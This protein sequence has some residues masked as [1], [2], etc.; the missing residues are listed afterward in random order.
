MQ[1]FSWVRAGVSEDSRTAGPQGTAAVYGYGKGG[2][3][4][5]GELA[6]QVSQSVRQ[7]DRPESE[8]GPGQGGHCG[9]VACGYYYG[10]EREGCV[11][12]RSRGPMILWL[13]CAC[14]IQVRGTL[15]V[16][17]RHPIP[18]R[19]RTWWFPGGPWRG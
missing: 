10:R 15:I 3:R 14:T 13:G 8:I 6:V 9:I 11:S 2:R 7:P 19:R 1:G 17:H 5:G 12:Q 16:D 4:R 18:G